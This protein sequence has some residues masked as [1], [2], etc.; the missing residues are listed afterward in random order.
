[1]Q[2]GLKVDK[3]LENY[4]PRHTSEERTRLETLLKDEGC[5]DPLRVWAGKN[6][7]VDG[8]ERYSICTENGIKF[9]TTEL[10]FKNRE[11]VKDWMSANQVGRRNLT[12]SQWTYHIG[13]AYNSQKQAVGGDR[14]SEDADDPKGSVAEKIAEQEN[15]S[16]S[17]VERA[18]KFADAVEAAAEKAPEIKEAILNEGKKIPTKKLKEIADMPK[19][20]ARKAAKAAIEGTPAA[21]PEPEPEP[22]KIVAYDA[23]GKKITDPRYI[24]VFVDREEFASLIR[25]AKAFQA[26]L[27]RL[28]G[29]AGGGHLHIEE[30]LTRQKF[31]IDELKS[32]TPTIIC[33]TCKGE[34]TVEKS[35]KRHEC[36]HCSGLGYLDEFR[37]ARTK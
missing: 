10:E 35:G 23:T 22:A 31:V 4:L 32:R 20:K 9:K 25:Q 29:S 7:I 30:I 16:V 24:A 14:K 3:E 17:T 13:R 28:A 2:H 18:G 12:G 26:D 15:V 37:R 34:K 5:L 6:I 27:K 11:A 36:E 8:M 1:M 19:G 33:K 21:E